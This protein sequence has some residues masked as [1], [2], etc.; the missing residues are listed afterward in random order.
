MHAHVVLVVEDYEDLREALVYQLGAEGFAARGVAT[1]AEA[2]AL[3]A[4]GYRPCLVLLDFRLP[5]LDGWE[6]A[7]MFADD[8][9]TAGI[10]IVLLSGDPRA[11][12]GASRHVAC[13]LL[14][15][16]LPD[17]LRAA[18]VEHARCSPAPLAELGDLGG[19]GAEADR[20]RWR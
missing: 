2:L 20:Q 8:P 16:L 13:V 12:T 15:P 10:P 5:D 6:V 18:V 11:V 7:E 9:R 14:K 17:Q 3:V 19:G 1:G 4:G